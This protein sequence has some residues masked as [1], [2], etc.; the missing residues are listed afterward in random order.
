MSRE[1]APFPH[2]HA[3]TRLAFYQCNLAFALEQRQRKR[4]QPLAVRATCRPLGDW[5]AKRGTFRKTGGG[6]GGGSLRDARGSRIIRKGEKYLLCFLVN[7]NCIISSAGR[8]S[9]RPRRGHQTSAVTC[10]SSPDRRWPCTALLETIWIDLAFLICFR[11]WFP[12]QLAC[13]RGAMPNKIGLIGAWISWFYGVGA[14]GAGSRNVQGFVFFFSS[15][16]LSLPLRLCLASQCFW[17]LLT[18]S[19]NG[20]DPR[21][22]HTT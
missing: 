14:C 5:F 7:T 18:L 22:P 10:Q 1:P 6:A 16:E 19:N 11:C 4:Q 3:H 15:I 17:Q 20:S 8:C 2:R 13:E 9:P 21:Q 12:W